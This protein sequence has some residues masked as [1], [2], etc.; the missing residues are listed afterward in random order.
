MTTE[1]NIEDN[2]SI[3][4][5]ENRIV[6]QIALIATLYI[7]KGHTL[8]KREAI[9]DCFQE[10]RSRVG[11]HLIWAHSGKKGFQKLNEA[12]IDDPNQW[13]RRSDWDI[14]S[15]WE[16]FWHGGEQKDAASHFRM[17]GFGARKKDSELHNALSFLNVCLPLTWFADHLGGLPSTLLHWCQKLDPIQGY[18]GIGIVDS[19]NRFLSPRYEGMIY[20]MAKRYPGLEIDYPL[21]HS[22]WLK[23][24]IKGGNWLTLLGEHWLNQLGGSRILTE[25]LGEAFKIYEYN[26]GIMIQAGDKPELGAVN[27]K[28]YPRH[29]P[30]LAKILKP[31]RIKEHPGVH[32]TGPF[33]K[34]EFEAWL[35]RFDAINI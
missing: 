34:E 17:R 29:Y 28:L 6:L 10:Y 27:R 15:G 5:N 33:D 13:L 21:N 11:E 18:A 20:T 9:A 24:G 2:L 14:R 25:K 3:T 22:L 26:N 1:N 7:E 31:I 19:P 12:N 32:S 30:K 23:N 4:D 8:Q 16:F 35:A